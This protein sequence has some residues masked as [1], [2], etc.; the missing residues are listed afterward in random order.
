[1]NTTQRFMGLFEGYKLAHGQYR[2][3]RRESDGKMAGRAVTV[4][5]PADEKNFKDHLSGGEYILV[6]KQ[7]WWCASL[8]I[9]QASNPRDRHGVQAE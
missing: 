9:L 6:P 4:S 2:V 5:E 8:F 7:V 3:Q 1:M